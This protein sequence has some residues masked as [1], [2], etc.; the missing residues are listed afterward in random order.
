MGS[1][2]SSK[3]VSAASTVWHLASTYPPPEC[4]EKP[5]AFGHDVQ[6]V[7][8]ASSDHG[9]YASTVLIRCLR[10]KLKVLETKNFHLQQELFQTLWRKA[11]HKAA[12][13][14]VTKDQV[15][16]FRFITSLLDQ[17]L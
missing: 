6:S 8:V 11:D 16:K 3:S 10:E 4:D 13:G 9:L 14:C 5:E 15:A 12:L 17:N 7:V 1:W 2:E